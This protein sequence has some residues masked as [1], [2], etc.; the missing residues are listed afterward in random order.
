M[1]E[2]GVH[3]MLAPTRAVE[4]DCDRVTLSGDLT[5]PENAV[6]IV[7]FAHGSGSSR[8]SPRNR[9]VARV[10][11]EGGL[12]TLLFDLLTPEE[13]AIDLRTRHLR[14]DIPLLSS[15]LVG[16]TDWLV[17]ELGAAESPLGYFGA[18]TGAA[19]AL[20]AAAR[21]PAPVGAVVSRGG[22]PDLAG[23]ALGLVRAPTLLIVG[24]LDHEVIRLNEDALARLRC[25]KDLQIVAGATH[26]F[27]EPGTLEQ[28]AHLARD[29]FMVHLASA[30]RHTPIHGTN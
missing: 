20:I 2:R 21:R 7:L 5:V 23:R 30:G 1:P 25:D 28:V 29:W 3:P 26:L 8:K 14:F 17:R 12:G 18:S 15:R 27:E 11:Q 19:A 22:R 16:A 4:I 9:Y 6:G 24:G 13:E 10:L